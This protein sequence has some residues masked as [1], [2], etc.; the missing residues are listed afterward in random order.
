MNTGLITVGGSYTSVD[1]AGIAYDTK[2]KGLIR[3][4]R[5]YAPGVKYAITP[6]PASAVQ[7]CLDASNASYNLGNDDRLSGFGGANNNSKANLYIGKK[8]IS[9]EEGIGEPQST[10]LFLANEL[11]TKNHQFSIPSGEN[12]NGFEAPISTY[13]EASEKQDVSTQIL[14]SLETDAA[15]SAWSIRSA[16]LEGLLTFEIQASDQNG[17]GNN[18]YAD[19]DSLSIF[20]DNYRKNEE[21]TYLLS[22]NL[23]F[24][25]ER[26]KHGLIRMT[27]I[28]NKRLV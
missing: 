9:G 22:Y 8:N 3:L 24:Q 11:Y 20:W 12:W 23:E 18:M 26:S 5:N 10:T 21:A 4:C 17:N 19:I 28:K 27:I 1:A 16:D 14:S 25:R 15:A 7:Y 6:N 13:V 2:S